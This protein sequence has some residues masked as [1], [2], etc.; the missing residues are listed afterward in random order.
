MCNEPAEQKTKTDGHVEE[1]NSHTMLLATTNN[2][3]KATDDVLKTA[4]GTHSWDVPLR[5][6]TGLWYVE[7]PAAV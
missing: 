5:R 1:L 7:A 4:I 2:F 3:S 6:G